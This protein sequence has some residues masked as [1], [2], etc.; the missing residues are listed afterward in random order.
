VGV[1]EGTRLLE[2]EAVGTSE[3]EGYVL[4]LGAPEGRVEGVDV[5]F[6]VP[7]FS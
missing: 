4:K 2:G 6:D 5:G 3:T 1:I 7:A